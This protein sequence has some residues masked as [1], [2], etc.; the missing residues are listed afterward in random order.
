MN[1]TTYVLKFTGGPLKGKSVII[2]EDVYSLGRDTGNSLRLG[3]KLVSKK[4]CKLVRDSDGLFVFD[5]GSRNGTFVN[6]F[7][8]Q[9]HSRCPVQP[10]SEIEVGRSVFTVEFNFARG[11]D[12]A[13]PDDETT[14]DLPVI[15][16]GDPK[17]PAPRSVDVEGRDLRF[18]R[19]T[20]PFSIDSSRNLQ[21]I[22]T[23]LNK[24]VGTKDK[25]ALVSETMDIIMSFIQPEQGYIF[26]R[27]DLGDEGF[28]PTVARTRKGAKGNKGEFSTT[29]IN[30]VL[31][32]GDSIL[33]TEIPADQRFAGAKSLVNLK[34]NSIVCS[35]IKT[36]SKFHGLV[37]VDTT[38]PTVSFKQDDLELLTAFGV[39]LGIMMENLQLLSDFQD[40]FLGVIKTLVNIIETKDEYTRGHSERV[41]KLSLAIGTVLGLSPREK[42][43][44][45]VS[46]LL[47][48]IGK[49]A[50]PEDILKKP[51]SLTS[52]E[53]AII[54]KHP[55]IGTEL[56]KELKNFNEI[57]KGILFHHE[58]FDGQGYPNGTGGNDIPLTARIIAVADSFDAMTSNRPYRNRLSDKDAVDEIIKNQGKQ[59]DE[60]VARAFYE[61]FQKKLLPGE[62][63]KFP[64]L[65]QLR[66]RTVGP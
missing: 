62:D 29:V 7:R 47:H 52:E 38:S 60:H 57:S 42:E 33:S 31:E 22:Y 40:L 66:K 43:T 64:S 13:A 9:P 1:K 15:P 16:L 10:N 39:Q 8:L 20:I 3:D 58:R 23:L 56:V 24:L 41:T 2:S 48:D 49:I 34:I 37:Y 30:K 26:L 61:A 12:G 25:Q 32:G 45:H 51:G 65:L 19:T 46:A 36:K 21:A 4:H 27:E 11:Q 28:R 63:E 5:L 53:F 18:G 14:Y 17:K 59:F 6:G 50:V 35:P 55:T 54:K 44:L